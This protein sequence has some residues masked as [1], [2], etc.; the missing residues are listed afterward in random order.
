MEPAQAKNA[1][2]KMTTAH[3]ASKSIPPRWRRLPVFKCVYLS[4]LSNIPIPSSGM[5][6]MH[7]VRHGKQ[8]VRLNS[9]YAHKGFCAPKHTMMTYV[10]RGCCGV[11]YG[12][13][14]RSYRHANRLPTD[15]RR[16]A[17]PC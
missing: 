9:D 3:I 16:A 8:A 5:K 4:W 13:A 11:S 17:R 14:M 10:T 7:I 15:R 1:I 12:V 2:V 6:I